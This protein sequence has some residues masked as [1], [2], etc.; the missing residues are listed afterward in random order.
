MKAWKE[1]QHYYNVD[2]ALTHSLSLSPIWTEYCLSIR[3]QSEERCFKSEWTPVPGGVP[4][5]SVLGPV[6]YK[7]ITDDVGRDKSHK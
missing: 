3:Q 1:L 7:L 4:Q 5:G 2:Q 6:V